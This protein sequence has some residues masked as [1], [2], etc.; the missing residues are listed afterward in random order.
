MNR[1]NDKKALDAYLEKDMLDFLNEKAEEKTSREPQTQ[2]ADKIEMPPKESG[3]SHEKTEMSKELIDLRNHIKSIKDQLFI[4]IRKNELGSAMQN[5]TILKEAFQ[6]YPQESPEEKEEK[7]ELYTD[8]I[9]IF[10]QIK[11]IK[12]AV[13]EKHTTDSRKSAAIKLEKK[14]NLKTLKLEDIKQI[15]EDTK[16]DAEMKKFDEA[17]QKIIDL[18]HKA[19]M[20]PDEYK[21]I[22]TILNSKIA[23]LNQKIELMKRMHTHQTRFAIED[24]KKKVMSKQ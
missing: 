7:K 11:K 2:E 22:R 4:N 20:I 14:E 24:M 17:T 19:S 8:I 23:E 9:S 16:N 21:H 13:E 15:M 5:Y 3:S 1:I 18:R 12:S 6:K 10:T